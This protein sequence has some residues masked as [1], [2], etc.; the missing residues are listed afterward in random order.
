[1]LAHKLPISEIICNFYNFFKNWMDATIFKDLHEKSDL[2]SGRKTGFFLICQPFSMYF[3]FM[4]D[5]P[6]I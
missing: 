3:D 4:H 5:V 2:V 6:A 1:M